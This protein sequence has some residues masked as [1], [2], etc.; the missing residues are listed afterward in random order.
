MHP[1]IQASL[2]YWESLCGD[3]KTPLRSDFD[4]ID[5]PQ[6]LADVVFV[7]VVD[8]GADFRFRV[9]GENA[10]SALFENYTGQLLSSLPHVESDGPL[11]QS[12]RSAVESGRPVRN[13]IEYVGPQKDFRKLDAIILP[14]ANEAGE[15]TYL[16]VCMVLVSLKFDLCDD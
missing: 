3:R 10:R 12:L 16:L 9:I 8:G 5:I 14:L 15:V 6:V 2:S 13:P 1:S 4:P 11:M 7:D